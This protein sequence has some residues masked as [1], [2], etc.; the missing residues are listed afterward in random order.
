MRAT[1]IL[2]QKR[3]QKAYFRPK[4]KLRYLNH[5]VRHNLKSNSFE[6]PS[7]NYTPEDFDL[8]DDHIPCGFG[9]IGLTGQVKTVRNSS[10]QNFKNQTYSIK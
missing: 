4:C 3:P 8:R 2:S 10:S 1:C 6:M 5:Y 9:V 7:D